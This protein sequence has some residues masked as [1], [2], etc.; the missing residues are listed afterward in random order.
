[1]RGHV[2]A[3]LG[4][5]RRIAGALLLVLP[6]AACTPVLKPPGAPQL[7][8][9]LAAAH[10]VTSDG[11]VLPIRRWLPDASPAKA[12]VIALH[13]FNDYSR[14]FEMPAEFFRRHGIACYAYDQRGFGQAPNRGF[15]AGT[16]AYT[17]DLEEFADAVRQNHP[18]L[19]LYV[20]GESMG[21]AVAI[22]AMTQSHPP[23]ADGII[24]SAPAVWSRSTMPWYQRLVLETTARTVPW[25]TVTGEGLNVIAS[26]NI[27]IL[28][29]LS[30]DP[31]VIKATRV[32]AIYGLVNL[33]DEAMGRI[34]RLHTPAL[35]LVGERDQIIP[36]EPLQRL[37]ETLPQ[38][39]ARVATYSQGYHLLLRDLQAERPWRDIVAWVG[40][41]A[42][43]WP[44]GRGGQLAK[45]AA[46]P[47]PPLD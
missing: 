35:V 13:G 11:A 18:G 6:L 25:L 30:R 32:D 46:T 9:R 22:A 36:R 38:P 26:D 23:A 3:A 31:W 10:F 41:R 40:H 44:S 29:G 8:P 34:D 27:E 39:P 43:P 24:L 7:A 14:A 2:R 47:D 42:K 28:R 17:H 12:A 1:M 21:A 19:P 15:W 4:A 37:I 45:T 16:A 20:L 33:M 5:L